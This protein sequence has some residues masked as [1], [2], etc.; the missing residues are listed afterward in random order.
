VVPAPPWLARVSAVPYHPAIPPEAPAADG[1]TVEPSPIPGENPPPR[2]PWVAWR[3]GIEGTVVVGLRISDTGVVVDAFVDRSSGCAM[4]DDAA[5]QA[6]REWRF[7]PARNGFGPVACSHRQ[8][9][10]FRIR[11]GGAVETD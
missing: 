9:V 3:R 8:Q 7:S 2:Y 10:V 6:L 11:D 1:T 5:T 4:L